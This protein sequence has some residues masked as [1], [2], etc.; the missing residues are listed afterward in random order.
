MVL[1]S[2]DYSLCMTWSSCTAKFRFLQPQAHVIHSR[3]CQS[4]P[5]R[6]AKTNR[7]KWPN[8]ELCLKPITICCGTRY[9]IIY[10]W[11]HHEVLSKGICMA[12]SSLLSLNA[13]H[14]LSIALRNSW[15]YRSLPYLFWIP[16]KI[17]IVSSSSQSQH[18]RYAMTLIH[19][20]DP[21]P[22]KIMAMDGN[23][24]LSF[25]RFFCIIRI[26]SVT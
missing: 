18:P 5:L 25:I 14:C 17:K 4:N 3:K 7:M 23:V 10:E 9:A 16:S 11:L 19:G 22:S 6:C 26:F 13:M 20:Q 8:S 15:N 12:V 24:P 2:A 21:C 1:L